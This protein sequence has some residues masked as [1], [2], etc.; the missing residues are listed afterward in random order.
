MFRNSIRGALTA[1]TFLVTAIAA[2]A[3]QPFNDK[4]FEQAQASG[5]TILVEVTAPWCPVCKQ[6]HPIL[7]D[8]EKERPSLVT[9]QVDF[10]SA[11]S[12]LKRFGVQ[13]QSTLI[14][15]KGKT[16][17]GRSTGQTDPAKIRGLIA[18]GF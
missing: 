10:D 17:M 7:S 3:A 11:K 6:Q 4:A 9:Y 8:V 13:M 15:F 16:E 5:K 14:V 2:Q 18:K 12:T 1:V